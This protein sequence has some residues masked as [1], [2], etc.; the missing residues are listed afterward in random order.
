MLP[1][2]EQGGLYCLVNTRGGSEYGTE[3]YQAGTLAR[4]QNVFDDFIAAGEFLISQGLSSAPRLAIRG[5][6]NGGLLVAACMLQRSELFGAV[7]CQVPV[8]DMF[9]YHRFTIGRYWV[10]DYGNAEESP[11]HFEFLRKYSPLHNVMAETN[12]PPI[13][14]TTADHDDRVVPAHAKKFAA[15]LQANNPGNLTLLRVDTDAGHGRGKPLSK[16]I[17]EMAD[18]Y[19]FLARS[20]QIDWDLGD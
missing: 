7:V 12:Y 4:K 17:D 13:L 20:L 18:I 8:L 16:V 5:G 11:E 19:S 3:W 2:L 1:W 10:S 6:S 15:T 9:R 14:I